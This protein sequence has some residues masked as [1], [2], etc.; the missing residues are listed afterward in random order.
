MMMNHSC[1]NVLIAATV[2]PPGT[3]TLL[4]VADIGWDFTSDAAVPD[5]KLVEQWPRS[6][7]RY[8]KSSPRWKMRI[9]TK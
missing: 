1:R 3:A 6:A 5:G 4:P 7:V 2:S 9:G 8:C